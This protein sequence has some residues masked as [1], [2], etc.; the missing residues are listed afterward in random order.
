MKTKAMISASLVF[1]VSALL[2]ASGFAGAPDGLDVVAGDDMARIADILRG[3]ERAGKNRRSDGNSGK[4]RNGSAKSLDCRGSDLGVI[5]NI[6]T[7][8]AERPRTGKKHP[9]A[10]ASKKNGKSGKVLPGAPLVTAVNQTWGFVVVRVPKGKWDV[11]DE[12]AVRVGKRFVFGKVSARKP[13]LSVVVDIKE[14]PRD[15]SVGSKCLKL[16]KKNGD[17]A[18]NVRKNPADPA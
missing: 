3:K 4:E 7:K 6:L 10:V 11:G 15:L 12:V 1:A 14:I 17:S 8:G 2:P 9:R 18:G 16:K 13:G 5:V